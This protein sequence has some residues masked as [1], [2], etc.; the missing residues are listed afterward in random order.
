MSI[1]K[2]VNRRKILEAAGVAGGV[3][4][5]GS[6]LHGRITGAAALSRAE[7]DSM[8]P[9]EIIPADEEGERALPTGP[10]D[11]PRRPGPAKTWRRAKC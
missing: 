3:T 4:L 6:A 10:T 11:P 2:G 1:P 5:V 9:D 8:T 7:R